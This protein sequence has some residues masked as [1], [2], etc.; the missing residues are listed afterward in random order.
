MRG[1]WVKLLT[2]GFSVLKLTV[3]SVCNGYI[4]LI[5]RVK[6]YAKGLVPG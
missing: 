5:L 4:F 1:F 3:T 6:S 2:E